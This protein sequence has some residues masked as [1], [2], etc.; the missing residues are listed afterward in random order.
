MVESQ[1]LCFST[2]FLGWIDRAYPTPTHADTVILT[3]QKGGS[4][5][6]E[7]SPN[8]T[9][10]VDGQAPLWSKGE[11]ATPLLLLLLL[12]VLPSGNVLIRD[13][14][15][16]TNLTCVWAPEHAE[17]RRQFHVIVSS[18]EVIRLYTVY[19]CG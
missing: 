18:G 16:D 4:V 9:V 12:L 3:V 14:L 8:T 11:S 13:V 17:S 5:L 6:L 19:I 15:D 7:C 1:I 2:E 10:L